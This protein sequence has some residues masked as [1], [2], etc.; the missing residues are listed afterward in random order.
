MVETHR[1]AALGVHVRLQLIA[2]AQRATDQAADMT[3]GVAA[4]L[5]IADHEALAGGHQLALVA[6]LAARFSVEGRALEHDFALLAFVEQVNWRTLTQQHGNSACALELLVAQELRVLLDLRAATQVDAEAAG[7][8][9]ALAL[10]VHFALVAPQVHLEA[11]LARDVGGQIRWKPVGIVQQEQERSRNDRAARLAHALLKLQ[12]ACSQRLGET[13]LLSLEH[14]CD[15]IGLG[16]QLRVGLAHDCHD[17]RHELVEEQPGL[18][19]LV[20]VAYGAS[21]DTAQHITPVLIRRHNPIG[22]QK[23]A[24]ANVISNDTQ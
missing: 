5:G 1:G 8:A 2:D 9:G 23:R 10:R 19:E 17:H 21:H 24:G 20:A 6:H 12:H 18:T 3:V 13:L 7:R 22:H 16:Q 15:L 4:L 14:P 11:T